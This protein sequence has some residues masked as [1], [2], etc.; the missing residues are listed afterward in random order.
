MLPGCTPGNR[1]SGRFSDF[2]AVLFAGGDPEFYFSRLVA[3]GAIAAAED[4]GV[5]LELFWSNW[6]SD[7]MV[8]QFKEAIE[9][10]PD[11]IAIMGHPG[12][13]AMGSFVREARRKGIVVT[14]LNVELPTIQEAFR[15]E[16]FGYVGQDVESSGENLAK[17]AMRRYELAGGDTVLVYGVASYPIR[18]K[19][20]VS[21]IEAFEAAEM[22]VVYREHNRAETAAGDRVNQEKAIVEMLT[23]HPEAE[24]LLDDTEPLSTALAMRNHGISPDRLPVVGF[25]LTPEIVDD[26]RAGYIDLIADQQPFLQGYLSLLQLAFSGEYGFTGLYINTGG[27]FIDRTNIDSV[28]DLVE[29][30]IR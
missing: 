26:I 22:N 25:D 20:T 11:G 6:D 10:N 28:A 30:G 7:R 4:L 15:E 21:A 1:D 29:R 3:D 27:G 8:R 12:E 17:A 16:G 19:R 18:G 9:R 24:L 13:A 5:D 14:S 2:D 23:A